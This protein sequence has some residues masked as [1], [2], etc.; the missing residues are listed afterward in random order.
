MLLMFFILSVKSLESLMYK[1]PFCMTGFKWS[2]NFDVF[3][4]AV[5]QFEVTGLENTLESLHLIFGLRK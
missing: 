5:P 3:S 4:V 1:S 2:K